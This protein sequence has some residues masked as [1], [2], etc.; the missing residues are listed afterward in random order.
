MIP[1]QPAP[2][3]PSFDKSVREP[4][5]RLLRQNPE[6]RT[7]KLIAYWRKILPDLWQSYGGICAYCAHWI[8]SDTGAATVDH[9]IPKSVRLDLAYEWSNF[10]LAAARFNSRKRDMTICD[11]FTLL[12]DSFLLNFKTRLVF[13]NPTLAQDTQY[14]LAMTRDCLD[15]NGELSVGGRS[16]WIDPYVRGEISLAHLERRAPFIAYELKRQNLAETIRTWR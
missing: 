8:P 10:R 6:I 7:D 15:L 3:P 16:H 9:F 13:P 12:P 11:P 14:L 1:V 2:E 4:G 5:Q